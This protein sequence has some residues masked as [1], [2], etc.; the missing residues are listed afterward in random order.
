MK[1]FTLLL[2]MLATTTAVSA[3]G[4][5]TH[6][7]GLDKSVS[8]KSAK[9]KVA[10]RKS[11]VR[12]A[13]AQSLWMP[14]TEKLYNYEEGEWIE[15]STYTNTYDNA[16]NL[17]QLDETDTE[18]AVS[19]TVYTTDGDTETETV[20]VSEDGT[21]FTNSS[22][23]TKTYDTVL[24]ELIV[25]YA[26]Y[27]WDETAGDWAQTGNSYQRNL[28]RDADGN[29]TRCAVATPYMGEMDEIQ[30]FTTT[31]STDT[32]QATA[33]T[34]EE[35]GYNDDYTALEWQT[36]MQLENMT[37]KETNGQLAGEYSDFRS[38]GN[39]LASADV[40]E[41]ADSD[42]VRSSLAITYGDDINNYTEVYRSG[43]GLY[44][45]IATQTT[46]MDKGEVVY[47][48]KYYTDLDGDGVFTDT[49]MT[50][51]SKE[52][53]QVDAQ[54]NTVLYEAYGLNDEGDGVAQMEGVKYEYTYDTEQYGGA[55]TSYTEYEYDLETGEYV[56]YMRV[57][58][59]D[60]I[61]VTSAIRN[62]TAAASMATTYY[63]LTGKQLSGQLSRGVT[64]VKQGDKVMKVV[65]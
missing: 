20:A 44:Y 6:N 16:G 52:L 55:V 47:E 26:A 58:M 43:D 40:L 21:T 35:L 61:D 17:L 48:Y 28:T 14:V 12:K 33:Y 13:A 36:S 65:R 29:L 31:F 7:R 34:A 8:V 63:D 30:R 46:D 37:W 27:Y 41:A 18:G 11:A 2:A 53:A 56:P 9:D 24:S 15:V 39:Y 59:S 23:V 4:R 45:S 1:H 38:Y 51:Y 5:F 42:V 54:G 19:R 50:D 57:D 60:F 64:I 3:Q 32:K 49:E 10:A 62:V 25:N 22:K